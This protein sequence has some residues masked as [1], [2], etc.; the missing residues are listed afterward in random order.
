VIRLGPAAVDDLAGAEGLV[1]HSGGN[2]S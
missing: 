1:C 2:L